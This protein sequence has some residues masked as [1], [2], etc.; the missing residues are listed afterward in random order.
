MAKQLNRKYKRNK[1]NGYYF[2]QKEA[3]WLESP[4][5]RDLTPL[6]R[7]LLDEFLIIYTPTRNGKLSMPTRRAAHRLGVTENTVLS[8]FDDL[9]EHGFVVMTKGELWIERRAR[10]WRLT[11][12]TCNNHEPTDDWKFWEQGKPVRVTTRKKR[13]SEKLKQRRSKIK[14]NLHKKFKQNLKIVR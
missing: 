3:E 11:M 7:C 6:A 13:R 10:E 4:A 5:Y 8:A 1:V 12:L 9:V 14:A 2:I